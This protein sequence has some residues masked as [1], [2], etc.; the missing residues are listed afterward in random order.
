MNVVLRRELGGGEFSFG[1][2]G[3]EELGESVFGVGVDGEFGGL[4]GGRVG[5]SHGDAEAGVA[6]HGEVVEV[7]P[8]GDDFFGGDAE[9][10][11]DVT[12]AG[13]LGGLRV[14]DFDDVNALLGDGDRVGDDAVLELRLEHEVGLRDD[15]GICDDAQ[16]EGERVVVG[17]EA[18]VPADSGAREGHPADGF[19]I[20]REVLGDEVVETG[21]ERFL[22]GEDGL[23]Q[24]FEFEGELA[25]QVR[26]HGDAAEEGAPA[27]GGGGVDDARSADEDA[28]GEMTGGLEDWVGL[29]QVSPG[30]EAD[31]DAGGEEGVDGGLGAGGDFSARVEGRAVEVEGNEAIAG[32]GGRN[33][34]HGRCG[35][36]SGWDPCFPIWG[37]LSTTP[38]AASAVRYHA[39]S[40][41]FA[42]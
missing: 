1:E 9:G 8:D 32:G 19:L 37:K 3:F 34:V 12:D 6:E 18:G 27:V 38:S 11:C 2:Q 39:Q 21:G 33:N 13:P 23:T 28:V 31:V 41:K 15:R 5:V 26:V 4:L 22:K 16:A 42:R 7:V 25:G 24:G 30:R 10:V 14:E 17:G 20:E 40:R 29:R 36:G 35:K